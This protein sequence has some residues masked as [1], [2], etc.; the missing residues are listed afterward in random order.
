MVEQNFFE[1]DSTE[2]M[3]Y[4]AA[5]DGVPVKSARKAAL[6]AS[7]VSSGLAPVTF[8]LPLPLRPL[9]LTLVAK[10]LHAAP[11]EAA[12]LKGEHIYWHV[13]GDVMLDPAPGGQYFVAG[14]LKKEGS[15]VWIADWTT[16]Q[17]VSRVV[18]DAAV[19]ATPKTET[20]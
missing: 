19:D 4:V 8:E 18:T 20:R 11:N 13:Q 7:D 5:I 15:S 3:F 6:R 16:G 12:R 17:R 1:D 9:R 14:E 10:H 2:E